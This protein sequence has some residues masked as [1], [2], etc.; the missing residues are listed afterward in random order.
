MYKTAFRELATRE[1]GTFF[2]QDKDI[3]IGDGVRNPRIVFKVVFE[4]KGNHFTVL[5]IT[6]TSYSGNITCKLSKSLQ[7]ISFTVDNISHLQNL[8]LRRKSRLKIKTENKN[9]KL[10]LSK[11]KNF[12][13]LIE[14]ANKD[15]FC[16]YIFCKQASYWSIVTE[17]HLELDNWLEVLDPLINLYKDLIDEF[18][19]RIANINQKAYREMY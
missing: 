14:I 5:N 12:Q 15:N 19:K 1:N 11:N 3:S 7:P 13:T 8:F 10:F 2:F 6:G 16:P 18:E 4:Y 17:Y 9:L